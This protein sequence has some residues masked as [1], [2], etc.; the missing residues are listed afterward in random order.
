MELTRREALAAPLA[1]A[2]TPRKVAVN[3]DLIR[4]NDEALDKQLSAQITEAGDP[5]RGGAPD[6]HGLY[7]AYPAAGLLLTGAASLVSE[8]SRYYRAAAL[9]E[10]LRLAIRYLEGKQH[11]DGTIDLLATNFHSTPDLGFVVFNV[12]GAAWIARTYGEADLFNALKPFL[13]KAGDALAVGGV[14]TPNHRWVVCEALS[15][16]HELMPDSRYV[17]RAEQWLAEGIDIDEGIFSERSTVIYN[18]VCC[19]ALLVT[20]LKL[21]KPELLEPVRQCLDAMLY[22]IHPD[23]EVVTEISTRQDVNTRAGM[24]R[25]WFPLRWFAIRDGNGQWAELVRRV[26]ARGASLSTYLRFPEIAAELP[27]SAALPERYDRAFASCGLARI[28]RGAVSASVIGNG[29][30][31]LFTLRNGGV[32]IEAVRASSAFFGKGQFKPASL[33][34]DGEACILTQSMQGPYYQP[35]EPP[36]KVTSRE[37]AAARMQ[38]RMSEVQKM[39]YSARI[40][41]TAKGFRLRLTANGTAHVPLA[42]EIAVRDGVA[43]VGARRVGDR[44]LLLESGFATLSAGGRTIRVGPGLAQHRYI[45]IRGAEPLLPGQRLHVCG[46][47]PFDHALEFELG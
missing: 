12:A 33:S 32:V 8:G 7:S 42:I 27:P 14:H 26:E 28:R 29:A 23:G 10:R 16:I 31:R 40:E 4:R 11:A 19:Q 38:R 41:E 21:N 39:E 34:R 36:R 37:L 45:E 44:D 22:L 47:T 9:R 18:T 17:A 43:I 24:E 35:V 30:S 13:K 6:P 15:Q 5:Q 20:A 2:Q 1:A 25:Y 46:L 3:A